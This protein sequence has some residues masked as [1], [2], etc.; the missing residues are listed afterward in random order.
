MW[1]GQPRGLVR[2][3]FITTDV[4]TPTQRGANLFRG[5]MDNTEVFFKV[6]QATLGGST[7]L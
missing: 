3:L 2:A 7:G 6:M 4:A 5:T 1:A